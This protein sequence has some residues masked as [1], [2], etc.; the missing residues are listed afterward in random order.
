MTGH[1]ERPW[2]ERPWDDPR[3]LPRDRLWRER[4]DR[5]TGRV[6]TAGERSDRVTGR[7]A[8]NRGT[9]QGAGNP[10]TIRASGDRG[11]HGLGNPG[12]RA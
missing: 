9:S 11:R 6:A 7:V 8:S 1:S 3:E 12:I 2:R 10:M 4:S 5:V